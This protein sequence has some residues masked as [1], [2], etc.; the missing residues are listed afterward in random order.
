M[1]KQYIS[2]D[3]KKIAYFNL[4]SCST[5][6]TSSHNVVLKNL[7]HPIFLKWCGTLH[8]LC[9]YLQIYFIQRFLGSILIKISSKVVV[10]FFF[11]YLSS[12]TCAKY[13]KNNQNIQ[14]EKQNDS[15]DLDGKWSSIFLGTLKGDSET[16]YTRTQQSVTLS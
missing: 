7:N 8:H 14:N 10:F 12:L 16:W 9:L 11:Y 5:G 6:K 2:K 3:R 13:L 1:N 15:L 4:V